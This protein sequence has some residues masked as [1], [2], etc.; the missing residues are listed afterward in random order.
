MNAKSDLRRW[1][2]EKIVKD[3]LK[4]QLNKHLEKHHI[5]TDENHGGRKHHSTLTAKNVIDLHINKLKDKNKEVG[6][7][8]TDLSSA[9]DTCDA[10]I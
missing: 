3:I 6:V 9:F 1:T 10:L 5:V 2:I 8:T 7:L 4:G